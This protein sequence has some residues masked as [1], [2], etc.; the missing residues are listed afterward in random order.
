VLVPIKTIFAI[1]GAYLPVYVDAGLSALI[2]G[3]LITVAW[4]AIALWLILYPFF[5]RRAT[6]IVACALATLGSALCVCRLVPVTLH[7]SSTSIMYA[8]LGVCVVMTVL[9]GVLS[10]FRH[11]MILRHFYV[12][13]E[14]LHGHSE[15]ELS[16]MAFQFLGPRTPASASKDQMQR[17]FTEAAKELPK[18][19]TLKTCEALVLL[20]AGELTLLSSFIRRYFKIFSSLVSYSYP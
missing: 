14:N 2:Y 6:N 16:V 12:T 11:Y 15:L 5:Y 4:A 17:W 13:G 10:W 18:S 7:V 19:Y 1:L 20:Q 3:I 9:G 8:T